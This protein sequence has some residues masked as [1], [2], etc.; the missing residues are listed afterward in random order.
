MVWMGDGAHWCW[1]IGGI[2]MMVVFWGGVLLL[3]WITVTRLVRGE[4]RQQSPDE[5]LKRRLARGEITADAYQ[6]PRQ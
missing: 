4:D 2:T 1:A 3:A 6:R 5:I